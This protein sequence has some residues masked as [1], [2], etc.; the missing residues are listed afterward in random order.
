[1]L[2]RSVGNVCVCVRSDE[3]LLILRGYGGGLQGGNCS[4]W[5]F[6]CCYRSIRRVL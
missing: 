2:F 6:C 1:M 5:F 3:V 4:L